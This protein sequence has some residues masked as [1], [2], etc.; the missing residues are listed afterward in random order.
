MFAAVNVNPYYAAVRDVAQFSAQRQL[1]SIPGWHFFTGPVPE[2][3]A[4]WRAYDIEVGPRGP[5]TDT[6]HTS[7]LYFIDPHGTE[8][9]IASTMAD[10][11]KAGSAYL[12]QAS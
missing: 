10:Y 2:L 8:R 3:R 1:T 12:P 5:G 7:A 4:V 6:I 11:T 9:Y